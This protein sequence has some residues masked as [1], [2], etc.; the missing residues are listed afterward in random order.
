M[1]KYQVKLNRKDKNGR[2]V[3]VT[4][5]TDKPLQVGFPYRHE[6]RTWL[7]TSVAWLQRRKA[8]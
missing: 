1:S 3:Q 8:A 6:N 7:V 5:P 4:I 2:N